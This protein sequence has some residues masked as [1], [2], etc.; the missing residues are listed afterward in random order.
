MILGKYSNSIIG[1]LVGRLASR[2]V[3][4]WVLRKVSI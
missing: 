4:K 3:G 2:Y 1:M